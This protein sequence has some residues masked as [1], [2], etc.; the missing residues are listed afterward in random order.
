[1]ADEPYGDVTHAERLEL[2]ALRRR[3]YGPDADILDDAP[4]LSRLSELEDRIRLRRHTAE[5]RRVPSAAPPAQATPES[6]AA[7]RE[8][9]LGEGVTETAPAPRRGSRGRLMLVA[10]IAVAVALLGAVGWATSLSEPTGGPTARGAT[11][12]PVT[13]KQGEAD[14]QRYIDGLRDDVLSLPG[15]ETIRNRMIRDQLRPYGILFGRTVGVG[16]TIDHKFCMIISNRPTSS[17][18]CIPVENAY[19]NPVSVSLPTGYADAQSDPSH[20]L[21]HL[22]AYTLMPGGSVVA[23]PADSSR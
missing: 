19:A 6:S 22:V 9:A 17:I 10:G 11:A 18:T 15:T 23:V 2:D 16:P 7:V 14:Y 12:P 5:P 8:D 1:V 20:G 21:G 4:A 13:N 3:A